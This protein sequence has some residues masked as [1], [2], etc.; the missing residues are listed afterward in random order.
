MK[1]PVDPVPLHFVWDY[2]DVDRRF[3]QE[4]LADWL[5]ERIFDAHVHLSL[6]EHLLVEPT[7]EMRRQY[8]V[9]ELLAPMDAPTLDRCDAT[10]WPGRRVEHLAFGWPSL[11]F[12]VEAQN[13]Y[14][15]AVCAARGWRCLVL[16][17]PQWPAGRVARE[18]AR[19]G[20]IGVKPYYAMLGCDADTRDRYLEASIF[21]FLPRRALDVLDE[22]RAWVTLHVP[23]AA[24][25]ADPRNIAEVREI[26]R[27]WPNVA[28]VI[29]HLGRSYTLPHA[30]ESLPR[31]ADDPGLY[32]DISAVLNPDVLRFAIETIGPGRLIYG[33]DNPV[34]YMRG[35]RQWRGRT[36]VN[37]TNYPFHF[38]KDREP[39]EVEATYTLYMYEALRALRQACESC[40]L[41]RGQVEA[42]FRGNALRLIEA[43]SSRGAAGD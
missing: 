28:L 26:R 1:S 18:L 42:I 22:R 2:T 5:P 10:V 20:V 15:S 24:R 13:N 37:R 14:A 3:W 29:A 31:L 32:F 7:D 35:R 16:L 39:P 8:W 6:P 9:N 23:G 38:N 27:R 17:R 4:H 11:N 19:P 25:L 12:D 40:G 30:E 21:D 43:A 33:T 34:F 36:Y 41:E